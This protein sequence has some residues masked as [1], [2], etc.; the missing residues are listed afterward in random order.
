MR[1]IILSAWI[2][3]YGLSLQAQIVNVEKKRKTQNGINL[4]MKFNFNL[5]ETG[6]QL[7][8]MKNTLDLQYHKKASGFILLNDISLLRF[9]KGD[10]DNN[11]FQHFRYNY[12]IRD[13]GRITLE[14]FVQHQYNAQKIL[15]RRIISGGGPRFSLVSTEQFSWYFAPLVMYEYER[16]S[17]DESTTSHN[18]RVDAYTNFY[19]AVNK[20]ISFNHISYFQPKIDNFND[21]RYSGETGLRIKILKNLALNSSFAIDYDSKPPAEISNLFYYLKNQIVIMF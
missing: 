15:K 3:L 5:K 11:G 18:T 17:D 2:M 21:F 20:T 10:L 7:L 14:A 16:L 13:T 4:S 12:T 8:L 6:S 19:F 9:D 1:T